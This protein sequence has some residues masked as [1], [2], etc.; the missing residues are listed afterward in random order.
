M[1][2]GD[3]ILENVYW[4]GVCWRM[5]NGGCIMV[6][7]QYIEKSI[8]ESVH[9]RSFILGNVY[10]GEVYAG[11]CILENVYWRSVCWRMC[12]RECIMESAY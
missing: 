7:V 2:A 3:C 1:F 6:S 9:W 12:N 4:R 5:Y 10:A 11:E 8:L